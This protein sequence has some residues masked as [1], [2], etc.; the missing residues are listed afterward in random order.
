MIKYII[1]TW[2]T[3]FV[4]NIQYSKLLT[5]KTLVVFTQ[6]ATAAKVTPEFFQYFFNRTCIA[7]ILFWILTTNL[8]TDLEFVFTR[9]IFHILIAVAMF[10]IIIPPS[11]IECFSSLHTNPVSFF[12]LLFFII[13]RVN[14]DSRKESVGSPRGLWKYNKKV[15]AEAGVI[16]DII[17]LFPVNN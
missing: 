12:F 16:A 10:T 2:K 15:Q 8:L 1:I 5:N 11:R 17:L 9:F 14:E 7:L 6:L 13:H 3:S 4:L